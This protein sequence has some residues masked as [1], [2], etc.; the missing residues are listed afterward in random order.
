VRFADDKAML[1]RTEK[2]LQT[3]MTKLN[4]VSEEYGMKINTKKNESYSYSKERKKEVKITISRNEIEQVKQF[5]YLGSVI[6]ENGRCEQ[7][8][9]TR[10]AI[11]KTAFSKR[12]TL[13]GGKLHLTLKTKLIKVLIW[14]IALYGAETW[15]QK[16]AEIQRLEALEMWLWRNIS[17]TT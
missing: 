2:G 9:K 15:S 17:T 7:E 13:L 16:K 6:P 14:S 5:R 10:I 3:L 1:S 12:K 8:I 4:D 11:A